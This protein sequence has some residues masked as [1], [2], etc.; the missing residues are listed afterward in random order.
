[1][2][3]INLY[4]LYNTFFKLFTRL[5][6]DTKRQSNEIQNKNRLSNF[7]IK[8]LGTKGTQICFKVY[9]QDTKYCPLT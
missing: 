6:Y 2:Y 5:L 1:M 9:G 4:D 3:E 8:T 7:S